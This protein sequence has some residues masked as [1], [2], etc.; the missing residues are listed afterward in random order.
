[1]IKHHHK[2]QG[3]TLLGVVIG[4][5]VGLA[6]AVVVALAITKTSLPFINKS[7]KAEKPVDASPSQATDPNKPIYGNRESAKEAAKEFAK[8]SEANPPAAPSVIENRTEAKPEAVGGGRADEKLAA[9]KLR[10]SDKPDTKSGEAK[11]TEHKDAGKDAT[12]KTDHT[13]DKWVYYLQAGAFREAGDAENARAK[14]ALLGFEARVAER[15]SE[16]GTLYR[17]RLGP[18]DQIET[19]NRVRAKLSESG[20]DVAI[21]RNSK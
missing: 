16:N 10:K 14:L 17:V 13:D 21:V 19:M 3:G 1:M 4:L 12:V 15:P 9:D 20:V 8:P 18:F 5:I 2:Q 6:I 11:T 7:G